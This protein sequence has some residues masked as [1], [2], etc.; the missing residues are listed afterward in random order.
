MAYAII[1]DSGAVDSPDVPA[2]QPHVYGRLDLP[3]LIPLQM[4]EVDL[5][6]DVTVT[7]AKVTLRT[8][9]WVHASREVVPSSI[10]STP[11]SSHH[12]FS[13]LVATCPSASVVTERAPSLSC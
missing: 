3:A 10:S 12:W 2:Y 1:V 6:V 13:E 7:R 9:W 4:R 8:R 11:P 5:H